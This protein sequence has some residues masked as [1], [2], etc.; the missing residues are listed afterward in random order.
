MMPQPEISALSPN[1]VLLVIR[2]TQKLVFS[3]LKHGP[4]HHIHLGPFWNS[5][6]LTAEDWHNIGLETG[7]YPLFFDI[8]FCQEYEIEPL[9]Q[10]CDSVVSL[11]ENHF[12]LAVE[13]LNECPDDV[14][15][16]AQAVIQW[17][18]FW[19]EFCLNELDQPT[20]FVE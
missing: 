12:N 2:S 13:A 9:L 6:Q 10:F 5:L 18:V 4:K 19:L 14:S 1:D 3:N 7:L 15:Y 11:K 17:I 16:P 20:S 8:E